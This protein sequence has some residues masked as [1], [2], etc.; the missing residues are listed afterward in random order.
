METYFDN[1]YTHIEAKEKPGV[2]IFFCR[3]VIYL[4]IVIS[5]VAVS[6]STVFAS[7]NNFQEFVSVRGGNGIPMSGITSLV[8]DHNGF[9]WGASRMGLMRATS[10]YLKTYELPATTYDAMQM[11]LAYESGV[12][13]ASTQNGKV[14]R[15][16]R[17]KDCFEPWF[18][19]SDML[20][21][22]EW[23]TN[24]L[25]DNQGSPWVSTSLGIFKYSEDVL[26]RIWPEQPGYSYIIPI[27]DNVMFALA[28]GKIYSISDS[29]KSVIELP[30]RFDS[31]VS[32]AAY[33]SFRN[34]VLMGT[35]NGEL[36][37]Y[38]LNE[39]QLRRLASESI[40]GMIIRS[41][42]VP[43]SK[44]ILIGME[45]SGIIV[46]DSA[47][48]HVI[49]EIRDDIDNPSSLKGNGISA[50]VSDTQGRLWVATTT[51][52]LQFSDA[53]GEE[54][55]RIVHRYNSASSLHNNEINNL[56]IDKSDNLWVATN[57]GI[58]IRNARDGS[59]RQMYGG[60]R[61]YVL[62]LT[63][64]RHGLI[65]ASTYGNGV[66]IVDPV[67]FTEKGHFTSREAR[68]FDKGNYVF[69]SFT[70]SDGDIWFG[71]VKGDIVCYS[72]ESG[73]F[74]EYEAH[75]VFC[76]A[77]ESPGVI[78]TGGGDGLIS[79]DKKTGI[80]KVILSDCVVQQIET[81][82]SLWWVCTSGDGVICLDRNSG[83]KRVLTVKEGLHS[84]FTRSLIR[85]DGRLWIG[86]AI[87][88]SCYDIDS[89]EMLQLPGKDLL[90]N[91]EFRDN[92][93]CVLPDGKLA[94]GT[95]N[96]IVTFFPDKILDNSS[97]GKIFFTDIKVSGRSIRS[98]FDRELDQPIDS[99]EELVLCH[100]RNSF[101]LSLQ[102][103]GNVGSNVRYSWRLD[104]VDNEWSEPSSTSSI[105]YINLDPGR[106][107]LR[108]RMHD[109]GVVSERELI[110][111][112][113]PPFWST[114]WFRILVVIALLALAYLL[115]RHYVLAQH[116]RHAFEKLLLYF[117]L[118]ENVKK[119]EI[120][121]LQPAVEPSSQADADGEETMDPEVI[122]VSEPEGKGVMSAE[123]EEDLSETVKK[124]IIDDDFLAR[125]ME[126]VRDNISNESFGKGEFASAM[127]ISQSLLYKKIKATA[128]MSVVEFIRSIRLNHAMTLL[129]S[130]NYNVTEVSEMCGF[131]SPAYFSRVFKEN[132][133][134]APSDIIPKNE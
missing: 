109:G 14:F 125:A 36:W 128:D 98:D 52:G 103:L 45:G 46:L 110:V 20:G 17:I 104:D 6:G 19:M 59:W 65:Y 53:D 83:Q 84:N 8:V 62:S 50:M 119:G 26:H 35:Y 105:N 101:T 30:G 129:T 63:Q 60:R 80:S 99:L 33:D 132:F 27:R 55:G 115:T 89:G 123:S 34:R 21:K 79:I 29:G 97:Q 90:T 71:G 10:S 96:G 37:E 42:L 43:N 7:D 74:R 67:S 40:P 5:L 57:D 49:E 31:I 130:G 92:S 69:A 91:E 56:L 112:V 48:G 73:R 108:I 117:Q 131:S 1:R 114:I 15:Y 81:E 102:A 95:N 100:P 64:D 28:A 113:K 4:F 93:S 122:S 126:C 12:L 72:P 107:T 94:F 54:A 68:I 86:T 2:R 118:S 38:D 133:G 24:I 120:P 78:L 88:M 16:D 18:S 9:V 124:S 58:S 77:E 11:K 22:T 111:K 134:M 44:S 121:Y 75:P 66:Y 32:S 70:D 106:Y 127:M 23:I 82:G 76:F 85:R 39:K 25:I 47:N 87:G 116:R 41:I 51:A 3:S 13:A 61:L